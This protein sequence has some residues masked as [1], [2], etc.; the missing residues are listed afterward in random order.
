MKTEILIYADGIATQEF[1]QW[2]FEA[3]FA[4]ADPFQ[5]RLPCWVAITDQERAA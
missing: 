1:F 4:G 5:L 3:V 2:P